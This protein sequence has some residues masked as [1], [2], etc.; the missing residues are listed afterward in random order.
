M[1]NSEGDD[2]MDRFG[3]SGKK[4]LVTGASSGIGQA[5]AIKISQLGGHVVLNGRNTDRLKET[6]SIM[7]GN[8]HWVMPYDLT[9]LHGIKDYVASCVQTDGNRFDGLVFSTGIG[10]NVP[11]RAE[12]MEQFQNTMVTN[13]YS[14]IALL[15][16]FSSKRTLNEGGSIV[17][18]SSSAG[19]YPGKSSL[20][21]AGSKSA[22]D[23]AT[24]VASDEFAER[25]IR[26]NSVQPDMTVTPMTQEAFMNI[27][28][29][30]Y[31]L[32]FIRAENVADTI[33]FLLSDMSCK[34]TGQQ[35]YI[36]AGYRGSPITLYNFQ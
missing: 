17:A 12:N 11:I 31:P 22:I 1:E 10:R 26:A 29:A 6:L 28:E 15:K 7:D 13:Y 19:K 16:V 3:L 4:Y 5:T 9:D 14:Y 36:S 23:T 30:E 32:K 20:C 34:I 24:I 27:S 35:I 8:K 33:I 25:R 21:Y 18:V 2:D